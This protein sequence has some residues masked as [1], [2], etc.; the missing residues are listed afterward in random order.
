M[1]QIL[2]EQCLPNHGGGFYVYPTMKQAVFADVP[3]NEHGL[4]MAPR[5][6]LVCICWGDSQQYSNGKLAFSYICPVK[7]LPLQKGYV[8][9]KA[10]R[11]EA[12]DISLHNKK[13]GPSKFLGGMKEKLISHSISGS[14]TTKKTL[15][16]DPLI[17]KQVLDQKKS[18]DLLKDEN[19]SLERE[20]MEME[21]RLQGITMFR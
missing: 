19:G 16:N 14:S 5:T 4:Y 11:R 12:E 18:S 9:T 10:A 15:K 1:G 8:A 13:K 21:Q 7:E 6:I 3:K 17:R 20:I 2:H